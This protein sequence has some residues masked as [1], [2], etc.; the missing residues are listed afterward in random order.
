MQPEP[1]EGIFFCPVFFIAS[2]WM[3]DVRKM[4]AYLVLPSR[5]K[6]YIEKGILLPCLDDLVFCFRKFRPG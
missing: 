1:A 6:E 2:N 4:D 5:F 3:T